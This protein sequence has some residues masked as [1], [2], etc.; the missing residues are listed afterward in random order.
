MTAWKHHS[1]AIW[2]ASSETFFSTFYLNK[3]NINKTHS[4][5]SYIIVATSYAVSSRLPSPW[6]WLLVG[7]SDRS[8]CQ[9]QSDLSVS[10]WHYVC[11][12]TG[13]YHCSDECFWSR[14]WQRRR[15]VER[16]WGK[17]EIT[18]CI[19]LWIRETCLLISCSSKTQRTCCRLS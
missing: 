2:S 19:R 1:A 5:Q 10:L 17:A 14:S 8:D 12:I 16:G 13:Q 18:D 9:Q 15:E 3:Q 11:D 4:D 6:P 7:L